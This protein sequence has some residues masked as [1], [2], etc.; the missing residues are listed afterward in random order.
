MKISFWVKLIINCWLLFVGGGGGGG[1]LWWSFLPRNHVNL[2]KFLLILEHGVSSSGFREDP[3]VKKK[4]LP[5]CYLGNSENLG[6]TYHVL[7]GTFT[8]LS[9]MKSWWYLSCFGGTFTLLLKS[10]WVPI[11]YWGPLHYY[12]LWSLGGTYHILG[13][14]Y[15]T[16]D[17]EGLVVPIMY[18]G[19]LYITIYYEVLVVPIMYWGTFTLLLKSWWVIMLWGTLLLTMKLTCL[20]ILFLVSRKN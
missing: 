14:L 2:L 4:S 9:T 3:K 1:Y 17:C 7:G 20:N 8:L 19:D 15:I 13:Y 5:V 10:W 11:M 6:G 18:W 12:P 16:I